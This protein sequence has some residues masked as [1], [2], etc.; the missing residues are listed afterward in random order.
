[1]AQKENNKILYISLGL[2]AL[3]FIIRTIQN[4]YKPVIDKVAPGNVV[5]PNG[6]RISDT[7][8]ANTNAMQL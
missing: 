8:K 5:D 6:R 4:K 7:I 1:M 3:Y 2:I